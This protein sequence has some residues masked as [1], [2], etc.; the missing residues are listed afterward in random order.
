MQVSRARRPEAPSS[1]PS[2][3]LPPQFII[4]VIDREVAPLSRD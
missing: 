4:D 1:A 2:S 3:P